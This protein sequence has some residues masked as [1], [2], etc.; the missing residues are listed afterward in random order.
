MAKKKRQESLEDYLEGM[1]MLEEE[2]G[3]IRSVDLA[4]L[5]GV[6]KPSVSYA[7]RKLREQNF[8]T[9]DE[10]GLISLTNDGLGVAKKTYDKHKTLASFFKTI[11]VDSKV[12][13]QDACRIEHDIS[14][15]TFDALCKHI[16]KVSSFYS[17]D[18][19]N[20]KE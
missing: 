14:S 4:R 11:G 16:E 20:H 18:K 15:E 3:F 13:Q 9:M 12:A 7:T 10:D 2:K 5:L 1:L 19:G 17:D 6:T 8:I